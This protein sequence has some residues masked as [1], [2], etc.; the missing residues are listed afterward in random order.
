MADRFLPAADDNSTRL[1]DVGT[2][3]LVESFENH[4][5]PIFSV[6]FT[7]DGRQVLSCGADEDIHLWKLG[8]RPKETK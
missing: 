5:G 7:P 1:W 6:A 8:V 2:G 3:N 4:R